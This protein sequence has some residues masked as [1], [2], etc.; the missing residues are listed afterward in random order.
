MSSHN[1][2]AARRGALS[3]LVGDYIET[4]TAVDR[5]GLQAGL[6]SNCLSRVRPNFAAVA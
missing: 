2:D 4:R 1:Y 3:R 5:N 6:E